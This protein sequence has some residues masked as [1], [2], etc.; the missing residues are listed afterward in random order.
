MVV[1]VDTP[2]ATRLGRG[3]SDRVKLSQTEK[4]TGGPGHD[5]F[6]CRRAFSISRAS[7]RR[8]AGKSG[9]GEIRIGKD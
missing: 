4:Y 8:S 3:C 1:V 5:R 9:C 7:D 2:F 6:R